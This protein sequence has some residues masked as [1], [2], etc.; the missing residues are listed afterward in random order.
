[1]EPIGAGSRIPVPLSELRQYNPNRGLSGM[2]NAQLYLA[3]LRTTSPEVYM[4]ALRKITGKKRTLGGLDA[5]L[6]D[7]M[8][9]PA[10]FGAFGQDDSSFSYDTMPTVDITATPI[11]DS[12]YTLPALTPSDIGVSDVSSGLTLPDF[13]TGLTE[14][15]GIDTSVTMPNVS[16]TPAPAAGTPSNWLAA[17]TTA[18]GNVAASALQASNQSNLIKLNTTRAQQGLPPVNANGQVVTSANTRLAPATG[19]IYAIESKIAGATGGMGMPLMLL[20]GV[21]LLVFFMRK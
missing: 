2:N 7:S 18:V 17:F 12:S 10:T 21:G 11:T 15:P 8:T 1:M 20:A 5:D 14:V 9:A 19:P 3:W 13:G 16:I 6:C 4:S